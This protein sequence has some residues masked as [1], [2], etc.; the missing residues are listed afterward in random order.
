MEHSVTL[1][2]SYYERMKEEL[3][4]LRKIRESRLV[5]CTRTA[6][7]DYTNPIEIKQYI[8]D[9]S[10]FPNTQKQIVDELNKYKNS[11]E[12]LLNSGNRLGKKVIRLESTIADLKSKLEE[13]E[14][15]KKSSNNWF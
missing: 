10:D 8:I 11:C 5:I 3:E 2:L 4:E 12:E 14:K 13:C 15:T 1:S 9:T 7:S 6:I